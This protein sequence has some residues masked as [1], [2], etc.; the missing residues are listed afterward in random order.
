MVLL[1]PK[2]YEHQ[3]AAT[4]A[5]DP[6]ADRW[7]ELPDPPP[8]P[9]LSGGVWTGREIVYWQS[10]E[11]SKRD[12]WSLEPAT[13]TWT[14]ISEDPF[15][16]TF[17]RSYTW[18]DDRFI[19][20]GLLTSGIDNDESVRDVYQ[21]AEYLPG[22][23]GGDWRSLPPSQVG[24]WDPMWF[25]HSG[26]LINPGQEAIAW[27]GDTQPNRPSPGGQYDPSSREWST[28]PQ[29]PGDSQALTGA[30]HVPPVGS[31]GEWVL[32]S[33]PVLVSLNPA[34]TQVIPSCGELAEP[35]VGV[36]TGKELLVWGGP[37]TDYKSNLNDGFAWA[38]SPAE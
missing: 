10:E 9:Y 18:V 16:A 38:P 22:D 35:D 15:A 29:F 37:A 2:L 26:A 5:F 8:Q 1:V 36:W 12:D 17:D 31:A 23:T 4:L 24:F 32:G 13:G 30:C 25:W 6:A 21:V 27:S 7:R 20:T 28:I 33:A 34:A 14:K 19:F 11:S 3:R